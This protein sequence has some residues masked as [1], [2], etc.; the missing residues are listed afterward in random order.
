M[1]FIHNNMQAQEEM[2]LISLPA[3]TW[4]AAV[5]NAVEEFYEEKVIQMQNI[6]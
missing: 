5:F 1:R 3:D 2:I 4:A 6:L